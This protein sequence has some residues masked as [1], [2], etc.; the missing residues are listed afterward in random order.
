MIIPTYTLDK[1]NDTRSIPNDVYQGTML[2]R[3]G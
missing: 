2:D 3:V 1:L